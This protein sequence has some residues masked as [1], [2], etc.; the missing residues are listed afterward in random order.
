MNPTSQLA[1]DL[2]IAA[3]AAI[4]ASSR[5]DGPCLHLATKEL[6]TLGAAVDALVAE[7]DACKKQLAEFQNVSK[8]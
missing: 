3:Q 4:R 8:S 7:L 1:K 6:N 2:S 5:D